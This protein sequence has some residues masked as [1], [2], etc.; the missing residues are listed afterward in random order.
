MFKGLSDTS[1]VQISF[2]IKINKINKQNILSNGTE[3]FSQDIHPTA[4]GQKG[5]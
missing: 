3:Y 2:S 4:L 5:L 1:I